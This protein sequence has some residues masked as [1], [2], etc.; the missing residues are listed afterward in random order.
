MTIREVDVSERPVCPGC[1]Q[2]DR[3]EAFRLDLW[4]KPVE[5]G[6]SDLELWFCA[7]CCARLSALPVLPATTKL[8]AH[9]FDKVEEP[10]PVEAKNRGRKKKEKTE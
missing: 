3:V 2:R 4:G 8:V 1:K 9:P 7:R 6:P 5:V 10:A